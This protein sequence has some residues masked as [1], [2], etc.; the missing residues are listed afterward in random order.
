MSFRW[1]GLFFCTSFSR[2]DLSCASLL[3][4]EPVPRVGYKARESVEH[5]TELRVLK[6]EYH[7]WSE[8]DKIKQI[9]FI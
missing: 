4:Y 6:V 5:V 1:R 7:V 9:V 8:L 2:P 3:Q